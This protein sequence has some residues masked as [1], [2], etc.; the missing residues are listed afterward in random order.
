MFKYFKSMPVTDGI[1]VAG[2]YKYTAF[3]FFQVG[4]RDI[5]LI[6][7]QPELF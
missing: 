4:Y 2:H 7:Q 5:R 6:N 1:P 3:N